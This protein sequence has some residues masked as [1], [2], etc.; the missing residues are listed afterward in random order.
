MKQ[1]LYA[2]SWGDAR[3]ADCLCLPLD[4]ITPEELK[5]WGWAPATSTRPIACPPA[6]PRLSR[7]VVAI[8]RTPPSNLKLTHL[9][10]V[11]AAPSPP[12]LS[13]HV[14][15][16]SRCTASSE[17]IAMAPGTVQPWNFKP[18][19]NL[20]GPGLAMARPLRDFTGVEVLPGLS[21]G[22]RQPRPVDHETMALVLA[23]Y[24]VLDIHLL[25]LGVLSE[26][27][28]RPRI[29]PVAVST[30]QS[31][32]VV[33]DWTVLVRGFALLMKNSGGDRLTEFSTP[34]D[35]SGA[36]VAP[37][38]IGSF[39]ALVKNAFKSKN[40]EAL[41]R[42]HNNLY[43]CSIFLA[44]LCDPASIEVSA[45][46]RTCYSELTL[47]PGAF[48]RY[49]RY[50]VLYPAFPVIASLKHTAS[51]LGNDKPPD[52][53]SIERV[54]YN[55]VFE[56]SCSRSL[57]R[58]TTV[59]E[60]SLKDLTTA[61][62]GWFSI[63]N[64]LPGSGEGDEDDE[65]EEGVYG[66]E[67]SDR[68]KKRIRTASPER[69]PASTRSCALNLNGA[70]QSDTFRLLDF[71]QPV[72]LSPSV[73]PAM[74]ATPP[75]PGNNGSRSSTGSQA[76]TAAV[77]LPSTVS[78][79]ETRP[80]QAPLA[81]AGVSEAQSVPSMD[82]RC[83]ESALS[84]MPTAHVHGHDD[85]R[86]RPRGRVQSPVHSA[87]H[88]HSSSNHPRPRNSGCRSRAPHLLTAQPDTPQSPAPQPDTPKAPVSASSSPL[89][90]PPSSPEPSRPGSPD[91]EPHLMSPIRLTPILSLPS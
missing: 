48:H 20:E 78:T 27:P 71:G 9:A 87:L 64:S 28:K 56:V 23:A 19:K 76:I 16:Y 24:R 34:T 44:S 14:S 25:G 89:S 53:V 61:S 82:E 35:G 60:V 2:L 11:Q 68:P 10:H 13:L 74:E 85:G 65:D 8:S 70:P 84:T 50:K 72:L 67:Q 75:D 59:I 26:A 21:S 32:H 90:S 51:F 41:S 15:L 73:N 12:E 63:R 37:A 38:S 40:N 77:P 36:G 4:A 29:Q 43:A 47:R 22:T 18:L 83:P 57:S 39:V 79:F 62:P 30:T 45:T 55:T 80:R 49:Q 5:G 91:P 31:Q 46:R 69:T 17:T 1:L 81:Q 33:E 86:S 6:F 88:G 54:L 66:F 7:S 42:I 3:E 52:M 58:H